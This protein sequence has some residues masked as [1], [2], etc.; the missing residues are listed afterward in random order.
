MAVKQSENHQAPKRET[1]PLSWDGLRR[2]A[3]V[4]FQGLKGK[5]LEWSVPGRLYC[6]KPRG[7]RSSE[8]QSRINQCREL[9][10]GGRRATPQGLGRRM[11]SNLSRND[12]GHVVASDE[13]RFKKYPDQMKAW[14]CG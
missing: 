3:D 1:V 13:S 7:G 8:A 5:G 10:M 2:N 4:T 6:G 14:G 9:V 12:S 11:G